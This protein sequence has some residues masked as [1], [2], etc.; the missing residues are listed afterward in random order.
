MSV[1][2][3]SKL[4]SRGLIE[5][6]TKVKELSKILLEKK[7][8]VYCGFDPTAD[9][10]HVG[11]LLPLICLKRFLKNGHKLF[12]LIGEG[13]GLIGDPSF[14]RKERK[15]NS[16]SYL[17]ACSKKIENQLFNFFK[18]DKKFSNFKIVNNLNWYK[19]LYLLDFLSN[20][21]KSFSVNSMINKEFVKKRI[22]RVDQGIS[23]SEFSYNI[24]QAY[25]YLYLHQRKGT[26]LQIGGSDQWGNIS[27]GINLIKKITKKTV[28]GL[29]LPLLVSSN[30]L[31]F[32]KTENGTIWLDSKK[33]SS[34]K[35]YQ[36]W[37]NTSDH[38]LYDFL[39]KFTFL[40]STEIDDFENKKNFKKYIFL[41]KKKL[42]ENVTMLVH[43]KEKCDSAKRITHSIFFDNLEKMTEFD[44]S[45]LKQDG[46]PTVKLSKSDDLQQA[47]V[48]S[49][50][51]SSRGQARNMILSNAV[52]VNH[53]K[54]KNVKYKFFCKDKIFGKYALLR[55]G[56]KSYCLLC[57][58]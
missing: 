45:Q 13:T 33:T 24:L 50:L 40:K 20:I 25:D 41:A 39:R 14:K 23:F 37:I 46:L 3:I 47:L 27:S 4:K 57:W 49:G 32:G 53:I 1:D 2:L 21:G 11:H 31:K 54:E 56:K 44:F 6:I 8:K 58:K 36:F 43:G 12:I 7:I 55:R 35:F 38:N 29:T 22:K 16:V 34:Y 26:V 5:N 17:N 30:G 18:K 48:K 15:P 51:S 10:L 28:F 42:A 9:S 19:N 52:Y